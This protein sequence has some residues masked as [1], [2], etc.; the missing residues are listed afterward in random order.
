[1]TMIELLDDE[2]TPANP[3]WRFRPHDIGAMKLVIDHY[4]RTAPV[5]PPAVWRLEQKL[6]AMLADLRAMSRG[7][8]A[9]AKADKLDRNT[10]PSLSSDESAQVLNR[11]PRWVRRHK[12]E[13]GGYRDQRGRFRFPAHIIDAHRTAGGDGTQPTEGT[14]DAAHSA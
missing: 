10:V 14:Q 7:H 8:A 4:R 1:M 12:H 6:G 5:V 3:P 11:H 13:L 2:H 9:T